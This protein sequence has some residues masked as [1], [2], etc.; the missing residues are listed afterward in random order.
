MKKPVVVFLI[1]FSLSVIPLVVAEGYYC[2]GADLSENGFV[3][4]QDLSIFAGYFGD[5]NC[6]LSNEWCDGADLSENGFVNGQDLSIFAGYFGRSDCS[7]PPEWIMNAFWS[8]SLD[9]LAGGAFDRVFDNYSGS[10]LNVEQDSFGDYVLRAPGQLGVHDYDRTVEKQFSPKRLVWGGEM[11]V[12]LYN[13]THHIYPVDA[14]LVG[15]YETTEDTK[16]DF[17]IGATYYQTPYMGATPDFEDEGAFIYMN[18]FHNN[19]HPLVHNVELEFL[20][21]STRSKMFKIPDYG[22]FPNPW[23]D[24][25]IKIEWFTTEDYKV[26]GRVDEGEWKE[27]FSAPLHYT[28]FEAIR[29]GWVSSFS[30][31]NIDIRNIT[32]YDE[33]QVSEWII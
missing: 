15:G 27:T 5:S 9:V 22:E 17:V 11:E 25:Y 29:F 24:R 1:L 6:S 14:I 19:N 28:D 18:A 23:P 2:D 32:L 10:Y 26:F 3:N 7:F 16:R 33:T 8:S 13:L 4:G 21:N 30:G 31:G 12:N 20:T